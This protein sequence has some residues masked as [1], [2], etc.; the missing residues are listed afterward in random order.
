[1]N[2]K[3]VKKRMQK[4]I[5]ISTITCLLAVMIIGIGCNAPSDSESPE[6]VVETGCDLSETLPESRPSDF[7]LIFQYGY[8]GINGDVLNTF[9][10][11]YTK[12]LGKDPS[13][14]IDFILS[15][16]DMDGIY[17]KM[18][19]TNFFCYPDKFVIPVPEGELVSGTSEYQGYYFRVECNHRIKV[20]EWRDN[21][22]N[23]NDDAMNLRGVIIRIIRIIQS[24]DEYWELPAPKGLHI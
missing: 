12:Y 8:G 13:V 14:T 23:K 16:E 3:M 6:S 10:G 11:T 15:D 21:I 4:I 24:K 17:Q 19:E 1:M 18:I 5:H 20:L 9:N 2:N 7:N 22:L